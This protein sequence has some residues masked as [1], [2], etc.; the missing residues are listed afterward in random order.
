MNRLLEAY[1]KDVLGIEVAWTSV[2]PTA[3]PFVMPA[4]RRVEFSDLG[5]TP[6]R[7][8]DDELVLTRLVG[9]GSKSVSLSDVSP[10]EEGAGALRTLPDANLPF[11]RR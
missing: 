1:T 8:L 5:P 11:T 10:S 4:P 7:E 6:T 3:S 2:F 9:R